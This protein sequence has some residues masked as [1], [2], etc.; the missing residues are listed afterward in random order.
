MSR[1]V[2]LLCVLGPL[3]LACEEGAPPSV[4]PDIPGVD[5]RSGDPDYAW[6]RAH[7]LRSDC[8]KCHRGSL[9]AEDLPVDCD[10]VERCLTARYYWDLDF[11]PYWTDSAS[12]QTLEALRGPAGEAPLVESDEPERMR[13]FLT[14]ELEYRAALR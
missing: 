10:T 2:L 9:A 11:E 14:R 8:A 12:D 13:A 1:G 3:A 4:H 5:P 7:G 6:S